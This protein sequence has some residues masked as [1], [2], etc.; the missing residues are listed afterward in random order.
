MQ[1]DDTIFVLGVL[2]RLV[3]LGDTCLWAEVS[4]M[5]RNCILIRFKAKILPLGLFT[6]KKCISKQ[7]GCKKN[8]DFFPIRAGAVASREGK[9]SHLFPRTQNKEH[10]ALRQ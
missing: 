1:A 2:L 4:H 10:K 6:N 5:H 3:T 9:P 7:M 8:S